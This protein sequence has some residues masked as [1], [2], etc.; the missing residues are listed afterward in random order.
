MG[1]FYI[2]M[3]KYWHGGIVTVSRNRK[4]F[5]FFPGKSPGFNTTSDSNE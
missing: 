5:Y 1:G 3:G 4:H 2:W